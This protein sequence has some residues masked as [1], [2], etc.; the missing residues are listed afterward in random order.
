MVGFEVTPEDI[1]LCGFGA[2]DWMFVSDLVA[3]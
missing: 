2:V 3:D 1:Y